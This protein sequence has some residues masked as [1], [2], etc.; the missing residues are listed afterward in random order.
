ME[1]ERESEREGDNHVTRGEILE[2]TKRPPLCRQ[3]THQNECE[4][5]SG[6]LSEYKMDL[7]PSACLSVPVDTYAVS[8]WILMC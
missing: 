7:F 1:R 6:T 5:I 8:M 4:E 2:E 3:V